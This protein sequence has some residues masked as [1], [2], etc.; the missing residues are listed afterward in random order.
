LA[1]V[2][3]DFNTG[4]AQAVSRKFQPASDPGRREHKINGAAKLVGD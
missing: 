2:V 3:D 1:R 4:I